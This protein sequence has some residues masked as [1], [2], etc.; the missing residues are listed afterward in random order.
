MAS[1]H[2]AAKQIYGDSSADGEQIL[3]SPVSHDCSHQPK[4]V[5]REK[6]RAWSKEQECMQMFFLAPSSLLQQS[7]VAE[8]ELQILPRCLF[9]RRVAQQVGGVVRH[10]DFAFKVLVE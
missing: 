9:C 2:I 8:H 3:R 10:Q 4:L 5:K 7:S 1:L 6:G